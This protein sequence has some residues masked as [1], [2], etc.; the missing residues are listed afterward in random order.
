M[1]YSA[2]LCSV[3]QIVA[4]APEDSVD[5]TIISNVLGGIGNP[6]LLSML[7]SRMFFNLREAA[8]HGVNKG[9]NW[10]SY[11]VTKIDFMDG[12]ENK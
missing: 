7:G 9:T 11:A 3:F 5:G 1:R 8:E 2:I 12:V 10:G 6:S 4:T